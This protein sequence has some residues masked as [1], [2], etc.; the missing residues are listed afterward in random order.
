M[1]TTK[2][3]NKTAIILAAALT[4]FTNSA[5]ASDHKMQVKQDL[6]FLNNYTQYST[7]MFEQLG[8]V[9]SYESCITKNNVLSLNDDEISKMRI[10]NI[11]DL[12]LDAT[13]DLND[14][15]VLKGVSNKG[16]EFKF[17]ADHKTESAKDII[18]E[19]KSQNAVSAIYVQYPQKS[20]YSMRLKGGKITEDKVLKTTLYTWLNKDN[21][22][23]STCLTE[24]KVNDTV[25]LDDCKQ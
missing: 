18:R 25:Y 23:Q 12:K 9:L 16:H 8:C 2:L 24:L 6:V 19:I 17:K 7:T 14:N 20:T 11:K 22:I 5:Q 10:T 21:K 4:V 15:V 1:K 3:I 13:V